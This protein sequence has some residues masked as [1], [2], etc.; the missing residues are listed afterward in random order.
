MSDWN[1]EPEDTCAD[2]PLRKLARWLLVVIFLVAGVAHL[3]IPAPFIKITPAWVPH[4]A[5]VILLTGVAELCGAVGLAQGISLRLRRWAAI[6]LALYSLC[7][8][9]A[10]AQHMLMDLAREDDGAG[11]A[12]HLPRM[13]LQPVVIWLA[14]W[15]G[16]V[17]SWPRRKRI[18]N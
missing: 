2:S 11:L 5:T 7:V 12:Y 10:N 15:S 17:I 6:G 13:L 8:W 9:P 1:G 16:G 14:L 3:A 18:T 4:P